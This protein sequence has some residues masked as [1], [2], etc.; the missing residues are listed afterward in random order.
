MDSRLVIALEDFPEEG[1]HLEGEVDG[2][3]F[4]LAGDE[5]RPAGPLRY[6]FEAHLYEHE[7]VLRGSVEARFDMRCNRCLARFDYTAEITDMTLSFD[8]KGQG[9]FD[10]TD[11]LREEILLI[12][13]SYPKCEHAGLDC[14]KNDITREFR[15]DKT[16]DS[17]VNS[18]A[19]RGSSVW[20]ALDKLPQNTDGR[21]P[22]QS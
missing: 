19:P 1:R 22:K 9:A 8:V 7:L 11:A 14:E 15:L 20:D 10:A 3:V 16:T 5:I 2:A 13:P 6:A 17:G 4:D 18:P 12:L 21:P